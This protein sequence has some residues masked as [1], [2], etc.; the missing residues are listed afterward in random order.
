MK[1][2]TKQLTQIISVTN[3]LRS[4]A[5]YEH[6]GFAIANSVTP[7]NESEPSWAWLSSGEAHLMLTTACHPILPEQQRIL[8]YLYVANVNDAHAALVADGLQ[9]GSIE[10]PFYAPQGEFQLTDPDGYVLMTSHYD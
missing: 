8:F 3:V 6:L 9:R 2:Q 10:T 4:I 1:T 7:E 5:F